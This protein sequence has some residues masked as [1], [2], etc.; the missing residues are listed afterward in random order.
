M[1]DYRKASSEK[2]LKEVDQFKYDKNFFNWADPKVLKYFTKSTKNLRRAWKKTYG[3]PY[4]SPLTWDGKK[5]GPTNITKCFKKCARYVSSYVIPLLRNSILQEQSSFAKDCR[6]RGGFFK[7]CIQYYTLN[8][9]ET[10]RNSLIEEGLIKDKPSSWCK[11]G[12]NRKDPCM[13]CMSDAMCTEMDIETGKTKHTFIG[14]YKKEH[15]VMRWRFYLIISC[16]GWG[17]ASSP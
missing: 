14:G 16:I 10:S 17:I 9:F 12:L 5:I 11:S 4:V 7:C 8:I 13:V 2:Q 6:K 3:F 1:H 15:R